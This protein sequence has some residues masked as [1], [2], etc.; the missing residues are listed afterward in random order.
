[1]P[2]T[3]IY[4]EPLEFF[5]LVLIFLDMLD[6]LTEEREVFELMMENYLNNGKFPELGDFITKLKHYHI[7]EHNMNT[8]NYQMIS[9]FKEE[10]DI[11]GHYIDYTLQWVER[12]YEKIKSLEDLEN[13]MQLNDR[14][15]CML[16]SFF[17]NSQSIRKQRAL[18]FILYYLM[19][20]EPSLALNVQEIKDEVV[21]HGSFI[22]MMHMFH[23]IGV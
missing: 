3:D 5:G 4:N 10:M 22:F 9:D 21:S 23:K 20:F 14:A 13:K 7:T 18:Y 2:D 16:E 17:K 8:K 12:N 1:M 6:F 19:K 15:L 11:D